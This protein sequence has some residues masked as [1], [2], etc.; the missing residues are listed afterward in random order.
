[1]FLNKMYGNAVGLVL[2]LGMALSLNAQQTPVKGRCATMELLESSL[3]K[4]PL[5][6]A[7]F[8]NSKSQLKQA[9]A[10]RLAQPSA[11][12]AA[13]TVY[14]PIVFHIV[15]TDPT[16]ITDA[17]IQAQLDTLNKD[18]AGLNADS[19]N[20]PA[21]FKPLFGKSIIQFKLAQRT[22]NDQPT[23][24]IVRKVTTRT[25]FSISTDGVKYNSSGGDN[26]WDPSRYLNIW[27]CKITGGILGYATLPGTGGQSAQGVVILSSSLPGGA[28]PFNQGRTLTHETGHYFFLY[29]IW[30]D[31]DG[32]CTG[33]DDVNDTPDQGD[34]TFGC[35]GG[36]VVTDNCT[37]TAPGILYEDYMDYVDDACMHMFT[38]EQVARMETALKINR[39]SLLTSN[40]AT[41]LPLKTLDVAL[42]SSPDMPARVCD[43][44][45]SPVVLMRNKGAATITSAN[46]ITSID[47][48][49][50]AT[51]HWNG[52]MQS[53]ANVPAY[54]NPL[55][56]TAGK[57]TVTVTVADPNGDAD[58]DNSNN[59]LTYSI[60][61]YPPVSIPLTEDFESTA[62]PPAGW[63]IV[64]PDNGTTWQRITGVSK[65]GNSAVVIPNFTYASQY[66][67]DYWRLPQ[68]DITNADSA[69]LSFQVAAAAR[70]N[71]GTVNVKIDTLQVMIS[72]DC[73]KTYSS[74]YKKAGSDLF[75]VLT[76]A[77]QAFVPI[78]GEW[79]KDS[80]DLTPYIN[81]GP[82]MLA[83]LNTTK[84]GNNVYLDD[85]R[86]YKKAA[87]HATLRERGWLVTPNPVK[88]KV[89][90]QFYP[91]PNNLKG[92]SIYNSAGQKVAEQLINAPAASYGSYQLDLGRYASG[93]YIVQ[94]VFGDRTEYKKIV[95]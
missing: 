46:I 26:A 56:L 37:G 49:T 45:V 12:I 31:D 43:A 51:T 2:M 71:T 75:T 48:A 76:P 77:S 9:V 32:D 11:R 52:T 95:K 63:D 79:R 17:Q 47:G 82:V 20:I 24:G 3:A 54:A 91:L 21:A 83:F 80:V 85:V 23:N 50:V 78:A 40:G 6:K 36:V 55:T 60:E 89:T 88:D 1:M 8:N 13:A 34:A 93:V 66:E 84:N 58:M 61:Y 86:I 81:K 69:F 65:S 22:P 44:S 15:L 39:S 42:N 14:V 18:F 38:N 87:V 5:L 10:Q 72:T 57:H 59:T 67:K 4:D 16:V 25:A 90:V 19:T 73:G 74:L 7:R 64:N 27:I 53:M 92:I 62:F 28:A 33:S 70:S 30:G 35:P 68:T 41:P 29:H 94:I